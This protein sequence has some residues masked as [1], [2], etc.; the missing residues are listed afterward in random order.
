MQRF[1]VIWFTFLRVEWCVRK[2]QLQNNS[3]IVLYTYQRNRKIITATNQHAQAQGIAIHMP[4]ADAQ[5]ICTNLQYFEEPSNNFEGIIQHIAEWC[6]RY[7]PVVAVDAEHTDTII[8]NAS[9]CPYLWG[10]EQLYINDITTRLK[11]IGYT[12]QMGMADTIGAA[13]ALSRYANGTIA[14]TNATA[15]ALHFLPP[16]ALRLPAPITEKLHQLGMHQITDFMQMPAA[17]LR[18]R[19]GQVL[20]TRLQQAL[21][22]INETIQPVFITQPYTEKLQCIQPINTRVGIEIALKK[23]LQKLCTRL[24]TEAKGLRTARLLTFSI[25]EKSQ[26]HSIGTHKASNDAVYLFSLFELQLNTIKPGLGIELFILEAPLVEQHTAQQQQIWVGKKDLQDQSINHLID[27]IAN[28]IG[29]E[30]VNR[31][32]PAQ[33]HWPERAITPT[34]NLQQQPTTNWQTN[35]TRPITLLNPPQLIQVTAPIPDY[36]PMLF[37]HQ[38]TLHRIVKADGPERIEQEWWIQ[39]GEHRDYYYVETQAGNRYWLFRLGHYNPTQQ[40]QW[41]LHGY[42]F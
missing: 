12:T 14:A 15:N 9:G 23:L 10:G 5:A 21:G 2:W 4:L 31:Y 36:P 42:C 39:D 7:S 6:I 35:N 17:Q 11:K 16:Q 30:T 3:P 24:I 32:L 26:S 28:K 1:V 19:F 20:I 41:F 25:D 8:I 40:A 38:G 27:K 13:W 33:H 18:R 37:K 22:F 29:P 34:N